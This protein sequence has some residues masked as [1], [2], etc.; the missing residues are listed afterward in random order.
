ME[1]QQYDFGPEGGTFGRSANNTWVLPDLSRHVSSLHASI[2][3]EN[4]RFIIIDQSTNGLFVNGSPEALGVNNA[5]A[6][7]HGDQLSFGDYLIQVSLSQASELPTVKR[8]DPA[9]T[10][11]SAP[12]AFMSAPAPSNVSLD[13]LDKW[14]EPTAPASVTPESPKVS[15]YIPPVPGS[16]PLS[17]IDLGLKPEETDPLVALGGANVHAKPPGSG[18]ELSD[19]LGASVSLD[20][21]MMSV[22]RII[23]NDW[24]DLLGEDVKTSTAGEQPASLQSAASSVSDESYPA[25]TEQ[26]H[27]GTIGQGAEQMKHSSFQ[28]DTASDAAGL[29]ELL[30]TPIEKLQAAQ[31][32]VHD[33]L[34]VQ[35]VPPD[36]DVRPDENVL[37]VENQLPAADSVT[38]GARTA[39]SQERES[40]V[41]DGL[42]SSHG[43][44][45]VDV[46]ALARELGLTH[47]SEAQK[48]VLL[49]TVANTVKATV[50]GMMRTLRARSEIKSEFRLNMTTIQSAENNPLKFSVTPED[51]IENMFAKQGKAY[52]P[53]VDAIDDGFADIAD[54]QVAL[55]DAMKAAYEHIL[56]QFDPDFL[57]QKFERNASKRFLGG[58]ARNW[59]SFQ[60]LY[61]EYKEDKEQT[62]KRLFGE[63]FADAYERRMHSLK[64]S[65][66][67]V[68]KK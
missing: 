46:E 50:S 58:K 19:L 24:D 23:P 43:A 13:D 16:E 17:S 55:F 35:G 40:S 45:M 49:S 63:V 53:P 6:L 1:G 33:V 37:P 30:S 12:A 54:H 51:A 9:A 18:G 39:I 59:E 68:S 22:P 10:Q 28:S 15:N 5:I 2:R 25:Q 66:G 56:H 67:H 61:N 26:E 11:L 65:R 47:L 31:S 20:Q 38:H 42:S 32:S 41:S 14:L 3:Y 48:T 27:Q 21:Q 62:F 34:P 60:L 52:L 64:M 4:G 29:S 36:Q 7:N 44:S 8:D 57:A